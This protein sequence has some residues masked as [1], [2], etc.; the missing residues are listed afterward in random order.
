MAGS[1][2]A[3]THINTQIHRHA[4]SDVFKHKC[5]QGKK[6]QVIESKKITQGSDI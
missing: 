5:V 4:Y 2:A 6:L 1:E 3:L